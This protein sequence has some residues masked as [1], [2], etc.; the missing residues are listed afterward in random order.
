MASYIRLGQVDTD[1]FEISAYIQLDNPGAAARLI[2]RLTIVFTTL[3]EHP[4]IGRAR[5]D[6][7]EHIRS[8]AVGRYIVIY[9]P[10]PDGVEIVRVVHGARYLPG[11]I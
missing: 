5:G 11:L 7:G 8:F 10:I 4:L 3:A 1:L 9:R 2:D 6:L